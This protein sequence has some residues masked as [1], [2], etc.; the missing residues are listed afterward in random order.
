[1]W[2]QNS[3]KVQSIHGSWI[4]LAPKGAADL[5]GIAVGSG[6]RIEIE[7]KSPTGK[8]SDDQKRWAGMIIMHGGIY[9]L[10]KPTKDETPLAYA[11]RIKRELLALLSASS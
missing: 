7:C 8:Q 3:G 2:R 10:A 6:K 4:E 1:V 9:V 11:V 5:T